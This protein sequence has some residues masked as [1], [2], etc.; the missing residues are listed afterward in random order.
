MTTLDPKKVYEKAS[1]ALA[2]A[3]RDFDAR[4]PKLAAGFHAISGATWISGSA[5]FDAYIDARDNDPTWAA[6]YAAYLTAAAR[7]GF[8]GSRHS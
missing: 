7:L 1:A 6:A 8:D 5:D 4:N 3:D 2:A